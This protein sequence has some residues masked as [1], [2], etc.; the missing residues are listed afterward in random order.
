MKS[1]I[2]TSVVSASIVSPKSYCYLVLMD[3]RNLLL[4][5][6]FA[7]I[8]SISVLFLTKRDNPKHKAARV[9]AWLVLIATGGFMLWVYNQLGR[10]N[11]QGGFM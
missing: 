8:V 4:L 7:F 1:L 5:I 10:G 9:I 3:L 11:G 2:I 6:P